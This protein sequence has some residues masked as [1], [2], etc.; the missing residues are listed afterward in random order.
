MVPWLDGKVGTV[1]KDTAVD[2]GRSG[3]GI[4]GWSKFYY[5]GCQLHWSYLTLQ[6]NIWHTHRG[7]VRLVRVPTHIIQRKTLHTQTSRPL[8]GIS[9]HGDPCPPIEAQR[10]PTRGRQRPVLS[11]TQQQ[12]G[13]GQGDHDGKIQT[14]HIKP[15]FGL[16]S[17]SQGM[18]VQFLCHG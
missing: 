2:T 17:L 4:L 13:R 7:W 9:R 3:M 6:K 15:G 18:L 10:G 8:K 1:G 12:T 11:S 5:V 14:D 16:L